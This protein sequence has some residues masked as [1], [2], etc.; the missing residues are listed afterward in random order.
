MDFSDSNVLLK[1]VIISEGI[2]TEK[3]T[4]GCK[5]SLYYTG[6]LPN[7]RNLSKTTNFPIELTLGS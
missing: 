7:D 4:T 3:P 1:K 5:V 2:G 6:L